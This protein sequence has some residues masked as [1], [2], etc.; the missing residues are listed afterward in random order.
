MPR[1]GVSV[2]S[3]RARAKRR[4]KAHKTAKASPK[5]PAYGDAVAASAWTAGDLEGLEWA[6]ALLREKARHEVRV[7]CACPGCGAQVE[8][9]VEVELE[10]LATA[11]E[12]LEQILGK[13][14]TG[15]SRWFV[16][17]G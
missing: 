7:A 12:H 11:A 13:V 8:T 15:A 6:I 2:A 1:G 17:G 14:G 9:T 10:D 5:R 3:E 16:K 4:A